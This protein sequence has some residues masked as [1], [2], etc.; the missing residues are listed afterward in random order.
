M[1][2]VPE[3]GEGRRRL[4]AIPGLPPGVDQLPQGCAFADRCHRVTE[5]CRERAIPLEPHG[6]ERSVRCIHPVEAPRTEAA[7]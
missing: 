3:L 5:A 4:E 6:A 2:C 7:Q 1:A